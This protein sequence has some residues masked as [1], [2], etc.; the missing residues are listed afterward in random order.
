MKIYY[1][2]SDR[3]GAT[4]TS[5]TRSLLA[6]ERQLSVNWGHIQQPDPVYSASNPATSWAPFGYLDFNSHSLP[7]QSRLA[8]FTDGTSNTML[9]SETAH[10]ARRHK[11]HRGDMLNDGEVCAYY[12][13]LQTP[14]STSPDVEL[15]V[16][17]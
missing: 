16:T 7:R 8:E 17:A 9:L 5:N 2:P 11:D 13:T 14:N 4:Q 15:A 1:C 3:P 12:M 10:D 6:G